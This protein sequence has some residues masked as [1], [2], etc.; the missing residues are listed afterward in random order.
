MAAKLFPLPANKGDR[1]RRKLLMAALE[2]FA[3][4]GYDS[5]SIREI[6]DA[7][8]Q[9]VA[10]IAYYFGSKKKLY[11]AL[12]EGIGGHLREVF[13]AS[14]GEM[15]ARLD[16]GT[17]ESAEAVS[18]LQQMM[19]TM[20]GLQFRGGDFDKVR[21][22]MIHEQTAPSDCYPIL[23]EGMLRPL[24]ERFT[25]LLAIARGE[26]PEQ[27]EVILRAHALFGQAISFTWARPTIVRRLGVR[28]LDDSHLGSITA[29]IDEHIDLICNS[30]SVS[31]R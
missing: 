6:A 20:I 26:D 7:A 18:G 27:P 28:Q 22:I 5:A 2:K 17:L 10:S 23:Y 14:A 25:R 13:A 9:N 19:R 29:L 31:P 1:A 4:K 16:G 15:L 30:H 12:L 24:H 3:A 8:G 11:I 21:Q